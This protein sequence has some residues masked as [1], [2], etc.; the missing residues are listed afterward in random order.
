[1][2]GRSDDRLIAGAAAQIAGDRLAD[3]L[4]VGRRIALEQLVQS[5]HHARRAEAALQGVMPRT[6]PAV[7]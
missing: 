4:V 7:A 3:L 1:M 5:Q 2:Q 6:L